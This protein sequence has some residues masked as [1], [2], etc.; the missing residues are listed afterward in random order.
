[1]CEHAFVLFCSEVQLASLCFAIL[2]HWLLHNM[3]FLGDVIH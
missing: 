3:L 1:M 2:Q